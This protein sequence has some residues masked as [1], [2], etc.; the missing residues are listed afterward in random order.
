MAVIIIPTSLRRYTDQSRTVTRPGETVAVV[1]ES[2]TNNNLELR[3]HLFSGGDLRKF[4][5]LCKNG[6][7][8]RQLDGL[9]TS[10]ES[11]DSVQIIASV[12]GG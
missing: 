11:S 10:L 6:T 5:V 8:I 2:L 9:D 12:A 1:L 7:D 4:V 3:N